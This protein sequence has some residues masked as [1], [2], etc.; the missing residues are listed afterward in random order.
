ATV[1]LVIGAQNIGKR[2]TCQEF[3]GNLEGLDSGQD[4]PRDLLKALRASIRSADRLQWPPPAEPATP[5]NA[6]SKPFLDLV[7]DPGAATHKQ[8][9]LVRKTHADIDGRRTPKGRR[10]WKAFTAA[11]RGMVL[12][13]HKAGVAPHPK[14]GNCPP[15]PLPTSQLQ[16]H[17]F[18]T[19]HHRHFDYQ[20]QHHKLS[21]PLPPRSH[22]EMESW[23]FRINVVAA[24]F[25]SPPFPAATASTK[26]FSRPLLP[27]M[28]TKLPPEEQMRCH[29]DR[30]AALCAELAQHQ[31]ARPDRRSRSKEQHEHR[32]RETYL[33]L[34]KT[35]YETYLRLL[36][37]KIAAGTDDLAV[38]EAA[39]G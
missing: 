27:S 4:F 32:L 19:H 17:H 8:G 14:P 22:E 12:Y 10:G 21:S 37:H 5:L 23:I 1:V 33:L 39:L 31:E 16:L 13:L 11:L 29:A 18:H 30:L 26:R 35:R 25:S 38:V 7:P 15:G 9:L 20:H 6:L 36:R 28:A 2:M 24:E 34:E 3:I